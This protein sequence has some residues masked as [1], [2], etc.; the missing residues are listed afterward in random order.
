[1][2]LG[3]GLCKWRKGDCLVGSRPSVDPA[4]RAALSDP[5]AA[6]WP[7]LHVTLSSEVVTLK[8]CPDGTTALNTK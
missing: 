6:R 3:T 7:Q 1:M 2:R 5:V 4:Q 8:S